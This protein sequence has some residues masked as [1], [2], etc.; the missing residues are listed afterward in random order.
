MSLENVMI[1][2]FIMAAITFFTR[3][4]PFIFFKN[5]N[6]PEIIMFVEK[7]IPPMIMVILVI[8][9]L[10]DIKFT[11]VPFGIPEALSI[12]FV[13]VMHVWKRN[14]LISILGGTALYMTLTQSNIIVN[15]LEHV[16]MR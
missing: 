7:Y 15:I 12:A 2:I 14:P 10:K 5:R 16:F 3:A 13:T 4:F 6:P 11:S 8:Y 1:S 9:C